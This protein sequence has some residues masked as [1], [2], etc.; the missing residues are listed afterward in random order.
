MIKVTSF[1]EGMVLGVAVGMGVAIA[2][3]LM[4]NSQS[5]MTKG[6]NQLER[7]VCEFVDG[8]QTMIR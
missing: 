4:M 7:A 1:F 6:K 5:K 2:G 8:V 3:K